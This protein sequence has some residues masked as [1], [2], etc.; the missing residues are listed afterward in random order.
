MFN[1]RSVFQRLSAD[2]FIFCAKEF[3]V[4]TI[5]LSVLLKVFLTSNFSVFILSWHTVYKNKLILLSVLCE[6]FYFPHES[7]GDLSTKFGF[8]V[9]NNVI[10][11][12]FIYLSNLPTWCTKF[13]FYNKFIPCLYMFRAPCAHHQEVKITLYSLC[14]FDLLMMSTWCSK[15][16]EARNELNVKQK[17]C[18][19]S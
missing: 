11:I 9:Q 18:A 10:S 12:S 19:S 8:G 3:S 14:N 2:S 16:V 17:F 6:L 15:H 5:M 7:M 13:L 1:E 4:H